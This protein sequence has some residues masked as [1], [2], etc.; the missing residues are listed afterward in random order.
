MRWAAAHLRIPGYRLDAQDEPEQVEDLFRNQFDI[1]LI[2]I[3]ASEQ[4]LT[5]LAG[6]SEPEKKRKIVGEQFIRV[7]EQASKK[8]G[9]G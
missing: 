6:V 1:D 7:F 4:F 3:D 5:A 8:I 2:C 9:K